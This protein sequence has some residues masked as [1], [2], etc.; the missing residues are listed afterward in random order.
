MDWF[1][2]RMEGRLRTPAQGVDTAAWLAGADDPRL[3]D[4]TAGGGQ[5]EQ[6]TTSLPL[7]H[8]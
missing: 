4:S 7:E 2:S 6:L 5:W 8:R 3:D 1:N